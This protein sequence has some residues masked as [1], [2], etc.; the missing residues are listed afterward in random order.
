MLFVWWSRNLTDLERRLVAELN[1]RL[2]ALP[3]EKYCH[4][5]QTD[6]GISAAEPLRLGH[7][8]IQKR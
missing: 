4:R 1:L 8:L 5:F 6:R 3:A 2:E 7:E